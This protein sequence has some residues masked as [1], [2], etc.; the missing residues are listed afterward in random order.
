MKAGNTPIATA[1]R[2]AYPRAL[3]ARINA[4]AREMDELQK[5]DERP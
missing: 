5:P 2:K 1:V 3:D 4:A